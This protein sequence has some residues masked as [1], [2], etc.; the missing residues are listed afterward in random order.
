MFICAL[1]TTRL[2]GEN[3]KHLYNA[4]IKLNRLSIK[5]TFMVN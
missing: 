3:I 2:L 4:T 5:K 1:S